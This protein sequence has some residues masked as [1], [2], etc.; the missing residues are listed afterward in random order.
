M[1]SNLPVWRS[2]LFLPA[3]IEKFVEKAHTRGADAYILDLEDSGIPD[4][5]AQPSITSPSESSAGGDFEWTPDTA[6]V[7]VIT[8]IAI[9]ADGLSDSETF[10]LEITP[11]GVAAALA[12]SSPA[13]EAV[14]ALFAFPA[15]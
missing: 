7:F 15:E 8:V 5:S 3:H 14:D 12:D 10:S 9:D 4:T 13:E 11:D 1:Q 6:G 2:A